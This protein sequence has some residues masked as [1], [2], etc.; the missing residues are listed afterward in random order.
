MLL[1]FKT[2]HSKEIAE[3][4]QISSETCEEVSLN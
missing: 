3:N 1:A 2:V 4:K